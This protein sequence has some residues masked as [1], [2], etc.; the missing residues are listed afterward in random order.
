[1]FTHNEHLQTIGFEFN[2]IDAIQRDFLDNVPN[3]SQL[4]FLGNR[5]SNR[6]FWGVPWSDIFEALEPCFQNFER[7]E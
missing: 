7:L 2:Q 3:V 4:N 1:M 6:F 5:C